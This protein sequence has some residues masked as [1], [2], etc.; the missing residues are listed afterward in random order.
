MASIRTVSMREIPLPDNRAVR[1]ASLSDGS[2]GLWFERQEDGKPVHTKLRVSDEA[3]DALRLLLSDPNS[4]NLIEAR[5][6]I[7]GMECH[8]RVVTAPQHSRKG[9]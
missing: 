5:E 2:T 4:G 1:L 9:E 8:W 3:L 7:A 6:K